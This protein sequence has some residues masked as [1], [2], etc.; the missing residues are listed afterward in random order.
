MSTTNGLPPANAGP[1]PAAQSARSADP[2]S[3]GSLPPA[4]LSSQKTTVLPANLHFAGGADA[5]AKEIEPRITRMNADLDAA[6]RQGIWGL[7]RL[8]WEAWLEEKMK[9][10]AIAKMQA[11]QAVLLEQHKTAQ[12][13]I[14]LQNT[15]QGG[16]VGAQK[17]R[18][19]W[20]EIS[21][22][23]L[24]SELQSL[25]VTAAAAIAAPEAANPPVTPEVTDSQIEAV[26]LSALMQG[27][28]SIEDWMEFKA[29]LEK[30]LPPLAVEEV[31]VRLRALLHSAGKGAGL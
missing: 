24:T 27:V 21:R 15:V 14:L 29:E 20:N 8:R 17:H 23:R 12:A 2:R 16:E 18:I 19:A 1:P 26:A 25:G 5:S 28:E 22:M 31:G 7:M 6:R 13:E 11:R 10:P 9:V 4:T 3:Y 30:H